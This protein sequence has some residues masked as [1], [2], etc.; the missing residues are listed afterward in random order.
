VWPEIPLFFG[1]PG[2][3]KAFRMKKKKRGREVRDAHNEFEKSS[4]PEEQTEILR[5][6][7]QDRCC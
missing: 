3:R 7:Y 5:K 2:G 4:L 6:L 1:K